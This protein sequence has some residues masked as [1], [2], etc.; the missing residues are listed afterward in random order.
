MGYLVYVL[1]D[2]LQAA[3]PKIPK[4]NP[5]DRFGI[6]LGRSPCHAGNVALVHNP[7]TLHVSLQFHMTLMINS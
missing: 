2:K 3:N 5:R 7:R 6:Y 4:W 1:D